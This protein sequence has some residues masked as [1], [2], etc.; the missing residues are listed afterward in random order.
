MADVD[1]IVSLIKTGPNASDAACLKIIE[2]PTDLKTREQHIENI[3]ATSKHKYYKQPVE[4][5]RLSRSLGISLDNSSHVV[6]GNCYRVNPQ[7]LPPKIYHY[8]VSIFRFNRD[9]ELTQEDLCKEKDATLCV[10][11]VRNIIEKNP[12]WKSDINDKPIGLA[13]DGRSSLYSS[14]MIPFNMNGPKED[15]LRWQGE[16]NWPAHSPTTYLML[17]SLAKE[18]DIPRTQGIYFFFYFYFHV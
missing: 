7:F 15:N 13:Y 3:E 1:A 8:Y 10:G 4:A 17:L 6:R 2:T 16:I 12:E 5:W 9:G 11:V 18:I 14:T